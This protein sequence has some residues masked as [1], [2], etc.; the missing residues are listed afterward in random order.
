MSK[1]TFLAQTARNFVTPPRE[2]H[3][4]NLSITN[5][6]N[7]RCS[8][9][10]IWKTY[11]D[12]P[13]RRDDELT[14]DEIR[15]L[16]TSNRVL[17]SVQNL[18]LTGGEPFLRPDLVE[19][20]AALH[21]ALPHAYIAVTSNGFA[22]ALIDGRLR[23]IRRLCPDVKLVVSLSLDGDEATH[24]AMRG[25]EG[26]YRRMVETLERVKAAGTAGLSLDITLSPS[27]WEKVGHA[28]DLARAHGLPY[29]YHM[30]HTGSYYNNDEQD[31]SLSTG[32]REELVKWIVEDVRWQIGRKTLKQGLFDVCPYFLFMVPRYRIEAKRTYTCYAGTHSLNIDPYGN[33]YPCIIRSDVLGNLRDPGFEESLASEAAARIRRSIAAKEC[34]CWT[35]CET[36]A[37]LRHDWRVPFF[38]LGSYLRSVLPDRT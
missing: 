10:T 30:A 9:C 18:A 11:K 5:R 24:D 12:H 4:L 21:Q 29:T 35:E 15:G 32:S 19:I 26:S 28:I 16:F 1:L 3:R 37:N 27:N 2:I 7:H 20:V 33:I 23:E 25:V 8:I 34:N 6:C 31:L 22:T 17:Q 14:L 36:L 38:N 13:E